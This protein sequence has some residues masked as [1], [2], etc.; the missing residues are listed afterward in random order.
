MIRTPF[1]LAL[2][3]TGTC[4]SMTGC[5]SRPTASAPTYATVIG[6]GTH[7][8]GWV[9][10][11]AKL[12]PGVTL[13]GTHG[14]IMVDSKD[15]IYVNTEGD[16]AVLVF[17]PD[18]TLVDKWGQDFRKQAHG[19][20]LSREADGSEHI[21]LAHF[22]R[23]QVVKFSLDGKVEMI[24]PFPKD[25][26]AYAKT[27]DYKPTAVAVAPNGD[28]YAADG[29]GKSWVHQYKADGTWIRSWDGSQGK[30]GKFNQ[31]HGIGIDV[32]QN[33]VEV[34]VCDRGNRRIQRFTLDGQWLGVV[35]GF[36]RPC[37]VVFRDGAVVVPDLEGRATILDKDWKVITQLGDNPDQ[38]QWAKYGLPPEQWKDGI[39][40]A[41]HGA[42]WDS[43]GNLYV[44]DWNKLGRITKLARIP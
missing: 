36:R 18:G 37:K 26:P 27:E 4:L 41:P 43:Q 34:A 9:Q 8:Y 2:L 24:L 10:D 21:W 23:H 6:E 22:G 32:R 11:W 14:C 13:G 42:A 19:M 3:A 39:F 38:K 44:Q 17:T 35:E 40:I 7:R 31:P 33:P 25:C 30:S 20:F 5:D 1:L 12:P 28:I 29:Y 16:Y 15:R